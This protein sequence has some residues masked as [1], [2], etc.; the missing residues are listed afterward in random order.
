MEEAFRTLRTNLEIT[1]LQAS[2]V[3]IRQQKICSLIEVDF[4]V[5]DS[6]LGGSYRR[7]TVIAPLG[8]ADFDIFVILHPS[9]HAA[10]GLGLLSAPRSCRSGWLM[11]GIFHN[12]I[13]FTVFPKSARDQGCVVSNTIGMRTATAFRES[14]F[15]PI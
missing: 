12:E 7:N 3:S 10:K 5:L 9:Y 11:K 13:N 1:D 15:M 2:T 14:V 6:F 8:E 4:Q